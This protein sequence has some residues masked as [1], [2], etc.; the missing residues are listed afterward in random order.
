MRSPRLGT[1]RS[2][3]AGC[4]DAR[5][6]GEREERGEESW[7]PHLGS[8][9]GSPH[10][11]RSMGRGHAGS[12]AK[13]VGDRGRVGRWFLRTAAFDEYRPKE[14]QS[15]PIDQRAPNPPTGGCVRASGRCGGPHLSMSPAAQIWCR[16]WQAAPAQGMVDG[17]MVAA[18]YSKK[19]A[20][21]QGEEA[22]R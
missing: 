21:R 16:A 22:Q 3:L 18:V 12:A 7:P 19:W 10:L 6:S 9:A 14:P 8:L 15:D 11:A 4:S 5:K 2:R 13:H 17:L 1:R 20:A